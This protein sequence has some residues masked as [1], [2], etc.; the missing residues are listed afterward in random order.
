MLLNNSIELLKDKKNLLAFS[1]GVDS[2]ALFFLLNELKIDFDIAIVDYSIR[3]QSVEEVNYAKELSSTYQ[4]KIHILKA[5]KIENNFEATARKIRYNFFEQ[6]TSEFNYDNLLTAH[7]LGDRFE[8]MLMQFCKGAGC[9]ELAGMKLVESRKNYNLIR[10]L[11]HLDKSELQNYL[12]KNNIKYFIDES[13]YDEGIKRNYFRVNH[14]TPL[15]DK[16]LDG[17]KKSFSYIDEDVNDLLELAKINTIKDFIYFN[18]KD[19]RSDI[20]SIDKIL[21][22]RNIMI[23]SNERNLLKENKTCVIA[24]SYVVTWHLNYVFIAP[25]I[26]SNISMPHKFK[27]NMRILKIEPKLR[28]YFFTNPD[29]FESLEG[30]VELQ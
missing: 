20:Y 9:A 18:S 12:D 21:K 3:E 24:R 2:S 25:Y 29:V 1:A 22:S 10:P 5:P 7:H 17:I 19:K 6:L 15:L 13:N 30:F 16:Y 23:S 8:W 11:L 27:E 28:A 26:S 14:S 4:K